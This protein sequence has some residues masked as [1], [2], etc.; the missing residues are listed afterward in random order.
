VSIFIRG[1]F[2]SRVVNGLGGK[3]INTRD[4]D[5]NAQGEINN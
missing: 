3:N 5:R 1:D 4:R 2:L